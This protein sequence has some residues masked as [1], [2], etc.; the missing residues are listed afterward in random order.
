MEIIKGYH[1]SLISDTVI[2]RFPVLLS[3]RLRRFFSVITASLQFFDIIAALP[4]PDFTE[5]KTG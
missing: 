4:K 3:V 5:K 1:I 2:G